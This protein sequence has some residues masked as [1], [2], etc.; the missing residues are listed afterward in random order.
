MRGDRV[1][2]AVLVLLAKWPIRMD[3]K[4]DLYH[5]Q[6]SHVA[7]VFGNG[8]FDNIARNIVCDVSHNGMCGKVGETADFGRRRIYTGS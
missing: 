3:F 1:K 7:A 5:E 6:Q 2:V 4:D 8:D